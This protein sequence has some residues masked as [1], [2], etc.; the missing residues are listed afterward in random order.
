LSTFVLVH[1]AWHGAWCWYK[2]IPRLELA[3]H[4]VIAL[5][6]PGLGRDKTPISE[7]SLAGW[8]DYACDILEPEAGNLILVGHS[9]GGIVISEIAERIPEKI[10]YLVYVTAILIPNGSCNLDTI[11]SDGDSL[12]LQAV[13]INEEGGYS[14]V[15]ESA[16]A[17]LFYGESPAEDIALARTSLLPEPLAPN[18]TP[19]ELTQE[20]FG[21]IARVY[22]EC[23]RDRAVSPALQKQ[24]YMAQECEKVI[25][26]DTDHSPF[27][28]QPNE[29]AEHLLS[30]S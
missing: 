17:E 28:S 9:R 3:G 8:I 4:K 7:V 24:M 27:F 14:T 18:V 19:L 6:L 20:K 13:D 1:G 21:S 2:L 26:M 22:I 23:L 25:S 30:L 15:S 11:M 10:K 16:L 5:D 29:L 12:L